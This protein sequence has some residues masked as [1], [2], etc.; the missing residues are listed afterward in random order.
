MKFKFLWIPVKP[1]TGLKSIFN[2]RNPFCKRNGINIPKIYNIIDKLVTWLISLVVMMLCCRR[3]QCPFVDVPSSMMVHS[4]QC[5]FHEDQI[6][7]AMHNLVLCIKR[8]RSTSSLTNLWPHYAESIEPD[9]RFVDTLT[10]VRR[11]VWSFLL[12]QFGS[13]GIKINLEFG[14]L[15]NEAFVFSKTV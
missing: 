11:S 12:Y 2:N 5:F 7:L 9:L 14:N 8:Q 3:L 15:I 6:G 4:N 10:T 13:T 1:K